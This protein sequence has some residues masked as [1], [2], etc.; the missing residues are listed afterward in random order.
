M[1]L[2]AID[3]TSEIPLYRQLHQAMKEQIRSARIPAG[4]RLLSVRELARRL[5]VSPITVVQAYDA[6][7]ADGLVHARLG[8]GTFAGGTTLD[9]PQDRYATDTDEVP[10]T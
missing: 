7:A 10:S 1:E 8:R 9:L 5:S 3:R 4:A 2:P 6:L